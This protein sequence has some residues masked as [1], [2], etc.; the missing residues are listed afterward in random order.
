[1][2]GEKRGKRHGLFDQGLKLALSHRPNAADET[3]L[4]TAGN[5]DA[6]TSRFDRQLIPVCGI[7]V[8][9]CLPI[10]HHCLYFS[11]RKEDILGFYLSDLFSCWTLPAVS[12]TSLTRE[13][14][15][16]GEREKSRGRRR[17]LKRLERRSVRDG[18]RLRLW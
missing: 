5:T 18:R 14:D 13:E 1:M 2:K 6:L 16:K 8:F 10:V 17:G 12:H 7:P 4:Y 3:L 15:E 11:S 9:C